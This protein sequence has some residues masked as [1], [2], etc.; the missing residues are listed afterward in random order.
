MFFDPLE[1][2]VVDYVG[3]QEDLQRGLVR[4]IGDPVARFAEDKLRML[5]AIRFTATFQFSLDPGTLAAI[6]R[7][8]AEIVVVSTER[9]TAELQ[10]MLVNQH[11]AHAV[12]LLAESGLLPVV[13]PELQD[14]AAFSA[15]EPSA[16][17]HNT[18]AILRSLETAELRGRF[19]SVDPG[20]DSS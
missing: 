14:L 16:D 18:L 9:V 12:E 19:R 2:R 11:R 3:G 6:Q 17:W 4:A 5:R 20:G 13:L 7:H 10:R 8:A 15:G 1:N